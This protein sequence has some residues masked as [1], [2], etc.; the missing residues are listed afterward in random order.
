MGGYVEE[1]AVQNLNAAAFI[2]TDPNHHGWDDYKVTFLL[3]Q[4][5]ATKPL[6]SRRDYQNFSDTKSKEAHNL[7]V[8]SLVEQYLNVVAFSIAPTV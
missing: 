7:L 4:N 5:S 8:N 6:I 3:L 1:I 2:V